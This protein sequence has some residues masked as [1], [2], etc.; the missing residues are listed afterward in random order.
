MRMPAQ[1]I[2]LIFPSEN[3]LIVHDRNTENDRKTENE[4]T[5]CL[6]FF[7]SVFQATYLEFQFTDAHISAFE[8][9]LFPLISRTMLTIT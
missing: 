1:I 9:S 3:I 5:I 6:E 7:L 2:W 8:T 4:K